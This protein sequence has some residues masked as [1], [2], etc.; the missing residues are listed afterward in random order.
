VLHV[1]LYAQSGEERESYFYELETTPESVSGW[2]PIQ[3][4]WED[5]HR[6]DWEANAGAPFSKTDQVAGM[7]FGIP[8]RDSASEGQFWV[9]NLTLAGAAQAVEPTA[10]VMPV[11][12]QAS[13]PT[14]AQ[15]TP[16]KSARNPLGCG[17][18]AT[19]PLAVFGGLWLFSRKRR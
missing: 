16:A 6:V 9:D 18:S 5:F 3:V 13:A 12:T 8:S 7:A 4:R 14:D 2:V 10:A 1:D 15:P 11:S 19:L 17:G